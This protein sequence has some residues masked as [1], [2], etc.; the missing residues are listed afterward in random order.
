MRK[1]TASNTG[2][3]MLGC[4]GENNAVQ[5]IWPDL[6]LEWRDL[7][8]DG[9]V[10][11]AVKRPMDNSPYPVP[12]NI[13]NNDIVWNVQATDVANS[14]FGLCEL[15]YLVDDTVVK[16]RV[17]KTFVMKSLS[18]NG[19][20]TPPDAPS[21]AWFDSILAQIGDLSDL[22][23]LAK[24]NLVAAINEAART[25]SG[26]TAFD[27]GPTLRLDGNTLSVN[28]TDAAEQDNTLPITSAGVYKEVGNI[29]ALLATI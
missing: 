20:T 4:V 15:T 2:M 5:V 18:G 3:L 10:Q 13:R 12:V 11:L 8:G 17:W 26:G 9:T 1:V 23:T 22:T 16:S 7:Y 6:L 14:G 27:I 24:S 21:K 29:N 19:T 28:T 25:G